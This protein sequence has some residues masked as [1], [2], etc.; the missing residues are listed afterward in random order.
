MCSQLSSSSHPASAPH[1]TLHLHHSCWHLHLHHTGCSPPPP[2][3]R[4]P[5][6]SAMPRHP[7][8]Q[9]CVDVAAE[10]L[11][12]GV[13]TGSGFGLFFALHQRRLS[14]E[15]QATRQ[16]THHS[17]SHT[18]CMHRTHP[19]TTLRLPR[20]PLTSSP[21]LF[22]RLSLSGAARLR[23]VRAA[24]L[25]PA[26]RVPRVHLPDCSRPPRSRRPPQRRRWRSMRRHRRQPPYSPAPADPAERSRHGRRRHAHGPHLQ[27]TR[28]DPARSTVIAPLIP[29]TTPPTRATA[30]QLMPSRHTSSAVQCSAVQCS[31]VQC[32]CKNV[33]IR[34]RCIRFRL[35][36][37]RQST[38][39][40][41]G[42]RRVMR[43]WVRTAGWR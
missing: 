18:G 40:V 14:P 25:L 3:A 30:P 36:A 33:R 23:S 22:S 38:C 16:V 27:R 37:V 1:Y 29:H 26:V 42:S 13:L 6:S 12:Q 24:V 21:S 35:A 41:R 9:S 17:L 2:A 39:A 20:S 32:V 8:K 19:H 28:A 5:P 43:S 34:F 15:P 11:C 10:G 31:T 4:R 7:L